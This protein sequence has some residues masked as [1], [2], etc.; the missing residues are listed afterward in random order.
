MGP[1]TV[2]LSNGTPTAKQ[3]RA[4][5]VLDSDHDC[6]MQRSAASQRTAATAQL[7]SNS[8]KLHAAPTQLAQPALMLLHMLP[9]MCGS[10]PAFGTRQTR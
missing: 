5:H 1:L 2:K 4:Q 9:H 10:I 6:C 7:H 8:Y 3:S